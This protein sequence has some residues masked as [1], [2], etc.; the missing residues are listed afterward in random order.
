MY[1][2]RGI[3]NLFVHKIPFFRKIS[4]YKIYFSSLKNKHGLEIGG[5]TDIFK[6]S[7]ILPIYSEICSLDNCDFA[8]DAIWNS[9]NGSNHAR[10]SLAL[11]S[12]KLR[13]KYTSNDNFLRKIPSNFYDFV[14]SS[15]VIEHIANPFLALSE[16]LRV[17]KDGGLILL[18]VPHKD[19]TFDHKRPVTPFEHLVFDF[20]N[21][22][23]EEDLTHLEEILKLHDLEKDIG[24]L[25]F[26]KFKER[27]LNN[28]QN[29]GLHHHVFDTR[30][31]VKILNYFKLQILSVD[32]VYPFHIITLAKKLKEGELPDNNK[33]L[34]GE[35]YSSY[36]WFNSD[37]I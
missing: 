19:G 18:V 10:E 12:K 7:G 17:L 4:N 20:N 13:N 32:P 31:V 16:W 22:T 1:G 35:A 26:E 28:Y 6:K 29:R 27:S 8:S 5:P 25:D 34:S 2:F 30:L 21:V 33:F 23:K 14:I 37:R 9:C 24:G 3:F 36:S 11:Y 15:H